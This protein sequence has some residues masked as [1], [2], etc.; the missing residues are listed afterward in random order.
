MNTTTHLKMITAKNRPSVT[1][2]IQFEIKNKDYIVDRKQSGLMVVTQ[3]NEKYWILV[4]YDQA[5]KSIYSLRRYYTPKEQAEFGASFWTDERVVEMF[6]KS[7]GTIEAWEKHAQDAW[8]DLKQLQQTYDLLY[9]SNRV[10]RFE[11][12]LDLVR[13]IYSVVEEGRSNEKEGRE[14]LVEIQKVLM[15]AALDFVQFERWKKGDTD[16]DTVKAGARGQKAA[17]WYKQLMYDLKSMDEAQLKLM[18]VK[19]A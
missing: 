15:M 18:N 6:L 9:Y 5:G 14:I 4:G 10:A 13:V 7:V 16:P 2:A 3:D 1:A 11:G 19:E 8:D 12:V 17:E